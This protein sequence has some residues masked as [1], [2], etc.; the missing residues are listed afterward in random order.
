MHCRVTAWVGLAEK[1][2]R[3]FEGGGV[4]SVGEYSVVI[5]GPLWFPFSMESDQD[6]ALQKKAQRAQ[7][8]LYGVMVLFALLPFLI[9]WLKRRGAFN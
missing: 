6:P 2:I 3:F 7:T 9:L 5:Q 1:N 8:I 4:H